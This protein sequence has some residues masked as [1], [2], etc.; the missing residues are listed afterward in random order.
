MKR[1]VAL[2]AIACTAAACGGDSE[3]LFYSVDYPVVRVEAV[4]TLAAAGDEGDETE[5]AAR[6]EALAAEVMAEAPVA[7][8]GSY[9]LDFTRFNGGPLTVVATPD[10]VPVTGE[11]VKEPGTT[12]L[13]LAF[14]ETSYTCSLG[15]YTSE[16]RTRCVLLLVN[17]TERYQ[18]RYPEAGITSVQ[19][20]EYTSTLQQ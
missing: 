1:L 8:G 15:S 13:Q 10:A 18:E 7:A 9:R 6:I 5:Q 12:Q 20:R 16:E 19:R 17:L 4:V 14:G 3:V 2:L 11:F